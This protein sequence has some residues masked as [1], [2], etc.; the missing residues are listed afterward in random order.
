M[1]WQGDSGSTLLSA[2]ICSTHRSLDQGKLNWAELAPSQI[3]VY[4]TFWSCSIVFKI[5]ISIDKKA[6]G[7][8]DHCPISILD[9]LMIC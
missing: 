7:F 2:S 4:K 1:D 3:L 5:I 9:H 8:S 6:L